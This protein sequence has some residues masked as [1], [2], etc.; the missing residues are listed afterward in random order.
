MLK[1]IFNF[2]SR[3]SKNKIENGYRPNLKID[4]DTA[5]AESFLKNVGIG[6]RV[7]LM[8]AAVVGK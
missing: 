3:K 6:F 8:Q 7:L 5:D 2:P 4:G 1:V